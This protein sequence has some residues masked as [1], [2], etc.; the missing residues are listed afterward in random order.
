MLLFTKTLSCE[1]IFRHQYTLVLAIHY[2]FSSSQKSVLHFSLMRTTQ[3]SET[4]LHNLQAL[5]INASFVGFI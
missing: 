1:K 4:K 3:G 5:P 2:K